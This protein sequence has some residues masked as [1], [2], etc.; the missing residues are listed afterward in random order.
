M[1]GNWDDVLPWRN[2]EHDTERRA[3]YEATEARLVGILECDVREGFLRDGQQV[4]CPFKSSSYLPSTLRDG[5]IK[6]RQHHKQCLW[7]IYSPAH[8]Q[9]QFQRDLVAHLPKLL[10]PPRSAPRSQTSRT[11]RTMNLLPISTRCFKGTR[12]HFSCAA[13]AYWML[14][15]SCVSEGYDRITRGC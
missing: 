15:S 9:S 3:L 10:L 6:A 12:A 1:C 7:N 13:A 14:L 4:L 5:A 2:Y 11:L 8:L